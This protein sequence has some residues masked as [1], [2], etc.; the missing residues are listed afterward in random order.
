MKTMKMLVS[1]CLAVCCAHGSLGQEREKLEVGDAMPPYV[2]Q[3]M[4]NYKTKTMDLADFR[5]KLLILDFWSTSCQACVAGWPKTLKIQE[6]FNDKIQIVMVNRFESKRMVREFITNRKK[7][8]DVDMYLPVS[9]ADPGIAELFPSAG[10]PAYAW[11]G[12]DG[13]VGSLTNSLEFT[14]EN[15][16]RWVAEGPQQL[17]QMMERSDWL[18]VN[19]ALPLF[20]DGNGGS[21]R[22][23]NFI[24]SSTLTKAVNNITGA[25]AMQAEPGFG[26]YI[27]STGAPPVILY[28][29]AY[30]DRNRLPS[31]QVAGFIHQSRIDWQVSD[32][33]P[34]DPNERYAFNYQLIAGR[35]V[36]RGE[37]IDMMKSDLDRYFGYQVKIEKRT[38][39]SLVFR[40]VDKEKVESLR[41]TKTISSVP[42]IVKDNLVRI[43]G[44]N[45]TDLVGFMENAS[46]YFSSPYPIEDKTGIDFPIELSANCKCLE[47]QSL[48]TALRKFGISLTLEDIP[49]DM[50]VVSEKE[51]AGGSR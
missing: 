40:V 20:V 11:I 37:L 45:F 13:V 33:R 9:C 51:T 5:G 31:N 49:V 7:V 21:E 34:K 24:W 41:T 4:I 1:L 50:L 3:N 35:P 42:A 47:Y 18:R 6:K 38:R 46:S 15:V 43:V 48:D 23:D 29:T 19:P 39:T 25:L 32:P 27:L 36:A 30:C 22:T 26:Y 16:A 28:A 12:A 8:T 2:L 10:V 44:A 14:E 17:V